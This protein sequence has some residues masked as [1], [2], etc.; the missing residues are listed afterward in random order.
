MDTK[1]KDVAMQ[2]AEDAR[3]AEW[4]NVA[5]PPRCSRAISAGTCVHPFPAQSAE[6]RKIGDD[7]IE[8]V[9][10]VIEKHVDPYKIDEEGEYP[11]AR[12]SRRWRRSGSSA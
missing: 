2:M 4:E 3:Q 1:A 5:S 9:R 8:K 7:Y 12:R 6:D 11:A 10:P